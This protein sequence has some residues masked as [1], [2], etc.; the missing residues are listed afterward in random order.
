MNKRRITLGLA[1]A[2]AFCAVSAAADPVEV[3][4]PAPQPTSGIAEPRPDVPGTTPAI[5]GEPRLLRSFYAALA[6]TERREAGAITRIT[7]L[8][9]S[10]IGMD[11][12][13]H[14]L[15]VHFQR[16]F[17]DA[18]PGYVLL[19]PHDE[20]YVNR[21]VT[22]RNPRRWQELCFIIRRCRRDGHY[23]LGGVTVESNGGADTTIRPRD[24]RLVT[25]AELWYAGQPR[26]GRIGFRFGDA[27]ETIETAADAL[28]DRWRVLERPPGD[29]V[30][31]V[32]AMGGGRVRGYGVVLENEGPGVVWDTLSMVGAFTHRLLLADEAH[33]ARQLAHRDPDLVILNY[34]GNDLRRLVGRAVDRPGLT[35]ETRLLLARIRRASPDTACLVVGI[36]DHRASGEA[37]VTPRHVQDVLGAQRDAAAQA[38]CVFWDTTAAMGGPGSFAQWHRRGLAAGDMKHLSEAGRR[39]IADRLFAALMA[40]R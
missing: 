38:G 19:Q 1:L 32:Q 6:R 26:G 2:T 16:Q 4:Q 3:R 18:G 25:R 11:G 34:G 31:R 12:L 35:E 10:S 9:D 29:H 23:G 24:G 36:N 39:V 21:T 28:E 27:E 13:P 40:G 8:G 14:P 5:E 30:V 15:R 7:H 20:N 33:F 17:G 22:L 37:D